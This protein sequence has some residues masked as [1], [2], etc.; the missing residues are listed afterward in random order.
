MAGPDPVR[1]PALRALSEQVNA[2]AREA[3]RARLEPG[4]VSRGPDGRHPLNAAWSFTPVGLNSMRIDAPELMI[5]DLPQTAGL[6]VQA[7]LVKGLRINGVEVNLAGA[8]DDCGFDISYRRIPVARLLRRGGNR[9]E[10]RTDESGPL[11]FL[12]ALILWGDFAVDTQGRL[13]KR[14]EALP[15]GP[16]SEHGYPQFCGSG[17]YQA[18]V[19]WSARPSAL[20]LETGGYPVSVTVDGRK[21]GRRAWPPFRFALDEVEPAGPHTVT[22]E[23]SGTLGHLF[24]PGEAPPVGL[25]AAWVEP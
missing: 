14:Q 18:T 13:V 6:S 20:I 10:V 23:V 11:K 2:Q 5:A 3:I 25:L 8:P 1:S 9:F 12:P 22:V 16:W 15:L 21:I 24:T 7:Q 17:R 4:C 19:E